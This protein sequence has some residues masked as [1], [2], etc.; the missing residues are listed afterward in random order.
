[1]YMDGYLKS[2]LDVVLK[3]AIPNNWDCV[4]IYFGWEGAGKTTKALQD[5][6]YMD[7]KLHMDRIVFTPTQFNE[8]L[9]LAP[10][11]SS[12]VWDEAITGA[13]AQLYAHMISL[14]IVSNLTQIR[15]KKLKILLCFPYLHMLNDY[16][17]KRSLYSI[18]VYAHSFNQRGYFQFYSQPKTEHLYYLMK[19]KYRFNTRI[20]FKKVFPNFFGRF[21]K[22]FPIDEKAYDEK[23]E[24]SR[25]NNKKD[26]IIWRERFIKSLNLIKNNT[27][28]PISAIAKGIG[29][30]KQFLYQIMKET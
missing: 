4:A 7:N 30:T 12:I 26:Y 1:M 14:A 10:E 16:F 28:Y 25:K 6:Y 22:E 23:K 20:A 24:W 13:N 3:E 21:S 11:G 2:E 19:E 15:K 17:V 18:N 29:V 9:N 27:D 8:S 5:A